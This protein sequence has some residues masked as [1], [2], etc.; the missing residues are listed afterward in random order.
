MRYFLQQRIRVLVVCKDPEVQNVMVALLTGFEFYVDYVDNVNEAVARFKAYRHPV[1]LLDQTFAVA[2]VRRL[3]KLFL[4]VQRDCLVMA[5]SQP[6]QNLEELHRMDP[7]V[8]DL[9]ELPVCSHDMQF[10]VRRLLRHHQTVCTLNFLKMMVLAFAQL[11]IPLVAL[12][13][14]AK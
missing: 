9:V 1:V 7:G 12:A 14:Y 13:R 3:L 2:Q 10:R 11:I 4:L 5:I 6:D 8:F